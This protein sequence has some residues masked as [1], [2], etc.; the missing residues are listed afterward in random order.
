MGGIQ[1]VEGS[2]MLVESCEILGNGGSGANVAYSTAVF[3]ETEIVGNERGITGGQGARIEVVDSSVS[4]NDF[5]GVRLSLG[6]NAL[7]VGGTVSGNDTYGILIES[8][9][10]LQ[11]FYATIENSGDPVDFPEIQ[12]KWDAGL[13]LG[14]G[15][16]VRGGISGVA[17]QCDD[18]ESSVSIDSSATVDPTEVFCSPF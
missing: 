11:V 3:S 6:S 5:E 14:P 15:A 17:V 9:S 2:N 4:D 13:I 1:V 10:V 8:H 18:L 12:L 7:L 16:I